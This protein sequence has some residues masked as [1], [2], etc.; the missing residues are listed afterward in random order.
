MKVAIIGGGIA[1]ISAAMNL[2]KND[3]YSVDIYEAKNILGGRVFSLPSGYNNQI[4]DNG[5]HIM[6]GAYHNFFELLKELGTYQFI[7]Y[8]DNF[9]VLLQ[10]QDYNF[11]LQSGKYGDLSLV[12]SLWKF[13]KANT[14]EKIKLV[15]FFIMLKMKAKNLEKYSTEIKDLTVEEYLKNNKISTEFIKYIFEP[16]VLATINTTIQKA[17]A[18]L[19]VQVLTKAFFSSP[20]NQ[21]LCFS[22]VPLADLFIPLADKYP[23]RL[24]I[25]TNSLITKIR[26]TEKNLGVFDNQKWLNYDAIILATQHN[27]I[28]KI[29]A[30][31]YLHDLLNVKSL[32]FFREVRTSSIL[33]IYFWTK[34]KLIEGDFCGVIGSTIHWIFKEKRLKNCYALT[35][36][37]AD[38][39]TVF[40]R[41]FIY[42]LAMAS[43]EK[44]IPEFDR[45]QIDHHR[46]YLD[47]FATIGINPQIEQLRPDNKLVKG[48]YFAGD[49]TNTKLPATME[50]AATSGKMAAKI[51]QEDFS[52]K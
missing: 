51:L 26:I 44:I 22:R 13:Q 40:P 7:K 20:E 11:T 6:V 5:K 31:S 39:F 38:D 23:K 52:I 48:I 50:S 2:L 27:F 46:M 9:E 30:T 25:F 33:S 15:K 24:K 43:L 28:K 18:E 45:N 12:Q 49:W 29:L 19:F 14:S 41:D 35:I 8:Q 10:S 36:S 47:K 37:A 17:P 1:G 3:D 16:I 32:H 4:I 34:Q 21:K 42:N